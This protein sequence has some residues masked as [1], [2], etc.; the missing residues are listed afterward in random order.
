MS[1]TRTRL[2]LL[3]GLLSACLT[4]TAERLVTSVEM[5]HPGSITFHPSARNVLIVNNTS[6]QPHERGHL[7]TLS[8]QP[9]TI[10][11]INTD[12]TA[13]YCIAELTDGLQEYGYFVNV[14][15]LET[16]Q[17]TTGH[18]APLTP[19]QIDSLAALY[20]AD[21][22]ITLNQ[23]TIVDRLFDDYDDDTERHIAIFEC[24]V[25]A[26]WQVAYPSHI[27]VETD[28]FT[29]A[30]TLYW[31]AFSSASLEQALLQLIDRREAITQTAES[32]GQRLAYRLL[33]QWDVQNRYLYATRDKQ[34]QTGLEHFRHR[35]FNQ[36]ALTFDAL[37]ESNAKDLTRAFALANAAVCYEL[38]GY[39][40]KA[41]QRADAALQ[42]LKKENS[43]K[44]LEA[45]YDLIHYRKQ[46]SHI[47]DE[48]ETLR[49]QL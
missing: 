25:G 39:V 48:H 16:T 34:L 10:D 46:L 14:S 5:L 31:E 37:G 1:H 44:A 49:Q 38:N 21:A 40:S 7:T 22:L 41:C 12:S 2:T 33:P 35:R 28:A 18:Y 45:Y 8:T 24:R 6:P 9:T 19:T 15:M 32:M 30:D 23:L 27:G 42:L 11:S 13:F 17:N 20:E 26:A 3:I 29:T 47:L 4:T 36:A 43:N